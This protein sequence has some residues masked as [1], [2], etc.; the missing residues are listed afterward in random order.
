MANKNKFALTERDLKLL[1]FAFESKILNLQQINNYIFGNK[2]FSTV[3]RRVRK[4]ET[5]GYLE[6]IP[7]LSND[8]TFSGYSITNKGLKAIKCVFPYCISSNKLK[9]DSILHDLDL[10]DIRKSFEKFSVVNNYLTENLLQNCDEFDSDYKLRPFVNLRSDAVLELQ[11]KSGP[12]YLALEYEPSLKSK[13]RYFDKILSYY[14]ES[15]IIGILYVSPDEGIIK[16]IQ[17]A[18]SQICQRYGGKFKIFFCRSKN[19]LKEQSQIHFEN[20]EGHPLIFKK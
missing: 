4:V 1:T 10:V 3:W 11:L 15:E 6:R 8:N 17:K 7:Y 13:K 9:S 14:S 20:Q 12:S 16:S 5:N 19:V 2:D 18:E